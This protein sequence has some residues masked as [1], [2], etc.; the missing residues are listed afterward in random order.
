MSMARDRFTDKT[1]HEEFRP[2]ASGHAP[3]KM[4][5]EP[6]KPRNTQG[7]SKG[8]RWLCMEC[9]RYQRG[10]KA[11]HKELCLPIKVGKP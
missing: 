9:C 1:R 5:L 11:K 3:T 2:Y 6:W 7:K 10:S 8:G 4:H